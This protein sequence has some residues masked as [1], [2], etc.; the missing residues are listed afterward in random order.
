MRAGTQWTQLGDM[1]D[2][3]G[4]VSAV[5]IWTYIPYVPQPHNELAGKENSTGVAFLTVSN[6]RSNLLNHKK[7]RYTGPQ[8]GWI[9]F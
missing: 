7:N 8:G 6:P 1:H 9:Q 2:I 3:L 4:T 5:A